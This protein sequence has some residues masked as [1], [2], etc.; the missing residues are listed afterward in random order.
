MNS[1]E[2]ITSRCIGCPLNGSFIGEEDCKSKSAE[3]CRHMEEFMSSD[4]YVFPPPQYALSQLTILYSVGMANFLLTYAVSHGYERTI[5]EDL[6]VLGLMSRIG[7]L[8]I[9][10]GTDCEIKSTEIIMRNG[11]Y[12]N[13]PEYA[14]AIANQEI[15]T[16]KPSIALQLLW[17]AHFCIAEDGCYVGFAENY[18]HICTA[19]KNGDVNETKLKNIIRIIDYL[20]I[21]YPEYK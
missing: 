16:D 19:Y 8:N 17:L 18:K 11:L 15:F 21:N 20:K 2:N 4:F 6:Y 14:E 3:F 5:A 9:P 12:V 10:N 7:C 13:K 1:M